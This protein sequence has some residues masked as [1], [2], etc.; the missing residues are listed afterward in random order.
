[1][2][3][4]IDVRVAERRERLQL[5]QQEV[6]QRVREQVNQTEKA[7][8]RHVRKVVSRACHVTP[9]PLLQVIEKLIA[10]SNVYNSTPITYVMPNECV[11]MRTYMNYI[12]T[13]YTLYYTYVLYLCVQCTYI[14]MCVHAYI[15]YNV[16]IYYIYIIHWEFE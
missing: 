2:G 4:F 6:R 9:G 10:S 13:K 11:Y 1:M 14:H 16:R 12:V 7:M 3:N 5:F 15:R 8:G